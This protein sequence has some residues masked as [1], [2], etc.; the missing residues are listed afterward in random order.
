MIAISNCHLS[1]VSN[2][3]YMRS[4]MD[5]SVSNA[6]LSS[7][8]IYTIHL[9]AKKKIKIEFIQI[10]YYQYKCYKSIHE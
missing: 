9:H 10:D 1:K 2:Y 5:H 8:L 6:A 4:D 3:I 7:I